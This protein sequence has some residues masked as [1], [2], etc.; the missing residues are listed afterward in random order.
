MKK[1]FGFSTRRSCTLAQ[2]ARS[3]Y[4]YTPK[5]NDDEK[6]IKE[7]YKILEKSQK[8]GCEMVHMKLRQKKILINHKRT[9]RIYREQG[10]Q[11][12]TRARRKKIAAVERQPVELPENPGVV[13]AMD[14][15]SDSVAHRRK[16]KILTVIDPV[17]NRS[18][19]IHPAFS[20][21][22]KEVANRLEI[23]K[24]EHGK[25]E[26]IQCD[27][28]PE[29]RSKELDQWCY[30]NGIKLVFSRPGKPTDNCHIESFN[31]TFRNECL[32][33]HYFLSLKDAR[34]KIID[35]WEEYNVERPQKRL[36]GMTPLE[37]EGM[38]KKRKSNPTSGRM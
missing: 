3:T 23:A 12:K 5:P 24:E 13:W 1:Y 10:L 36:K 26:Y 28:G 8:Y 6:I 21:N 34:E 11:I 30:E 9:E 32:N 37:Y 14:F 20:I 38:L 25:P 27:N 22:G 15:V 29:F 35:W 33:S 17:S 31:G 18:P 19:L 2:I 7:I 16:L 4:L